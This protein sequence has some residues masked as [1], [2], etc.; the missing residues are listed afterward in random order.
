MNRTKICWVNGDDGEKGWTWNPIVGCSRGCS[1][2]YAAR[3][4]MRFNDRYAGMIVSGRAEPAT[5]LMR[6]ELDESGL[7]E[8]RFNNPLFIRERLIEPTCVHTPSWIF[9]CSMGELFD[10]MVLDDWRDRV[11]HAMREAPQHTYV[12]LTKRP[13]TM[14]AVLHSTRWIPNLIV[15]VSLDT[16]SAAR[17]CDARDCIDRLTD[18]GY[19][20]MLSVE[21]MLSRYGNLKWQIKTKAAF[22]WLN[23][24]IIGAQTGPGAIP[25][26]PEWVVELVEAADAAGVPVWTKDNLKGICPETHWRRQRPEV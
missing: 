24:L 10:P 26:K 11:F 21:P 22:K 3:N 15:G 6:S 8:W 20:T 5:R 25:P 7:E 14:H 12:A 1:Y 23:W 18:R 2:C 16:E 13:R 9:V 17:L 4:A 19:T